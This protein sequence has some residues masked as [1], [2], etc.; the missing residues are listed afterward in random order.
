L[1]LLIFDFR[2]LIVRLVHAEKSMRSSP[3]YAERLAIR[4]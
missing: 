4:R 1:G 2:L 3:K